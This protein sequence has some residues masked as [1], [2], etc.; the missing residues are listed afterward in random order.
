MSEFSFSF[1][2]N[3]EQD[4]VLTNLLNPFGM[5][6]TV[7]E[8]GTCEINNT[9]SPFPIQTIQHQVC[10]QN[11]IVEHC[12]NTNAYNNNNMFQPQ[13]T[14]PSVKTEG[15]KNNTTTRRR[16]N[17]PEKMAEMEV[18]LTKEDWTFLE[19]LKQQQEAFGG[20]VEQLKVQYL[21]LLDSGKILNEKQKSIKNASECT[22]KIQELEQQ[23]TQL[24][25]SLYEM[26]NKLNEIGEQN[27]ALRNSFIT[28]ENQQK[29]KL[30][31]LSNEKDV[32]EKRNIELQNS[33]TTLK[34]QQHEEKEEE[35]KTPSIEDNALECKHNGALTSILQ[36][37]RELC[38]SRGDFSLTTKKR[39]MEHDGPFDSKL[40]EIRQCI[41]TLKNMVSRDDTEVYDLIPEDEVIEIR[42]MLLSLAN[43]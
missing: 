1:E 42:K 30:R 19:G 28:F 39:K 18:H 26:Q 34:N 32:L 5:D 24:K 21:L 41:D 17:N 35:Q 14:S 33:I 6:E 23:N 12:V 20:F 4:D 2:Q 36:D 15:K 10:N 40:C 13:Y 11:P 8:N 38:N 22:T 31:N 29:E 27:N 25:Q 43:D 3:Q 16:H 7:Q 37:L 9:F